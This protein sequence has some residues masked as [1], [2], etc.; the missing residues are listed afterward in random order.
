VTLL[1]LGLAPSAKAKLSVAGD[2]CD[3]VGTAAA[4]VN[5]TL[6]VWL[7]SPHEIETEP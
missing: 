6:T 2:A 3:P 7:T 5:V 4:T 1:L